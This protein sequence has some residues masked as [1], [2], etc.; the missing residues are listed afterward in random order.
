MGSPFGCIL[1]FQNVNLS[2]EAKPKGPLIK[3]IVLHSFI[4]RKII[5]F[6]NLGVP[7]LFLWLEDIF[8]V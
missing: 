6:D 4:T 7:F 3:T 2:L 8:A 1:R 5:I